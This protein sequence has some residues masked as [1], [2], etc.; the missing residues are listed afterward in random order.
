MATDTKPLRA[1]AVSR[2]LGKAHRRSESYGSM[3]RGIRRHTD[4]FEVFEPTDA[5]VGQ[6]VGV[7]HVNDS[8]RRG[9]E[10]QQ[11]MHSML[12]RYERTLREAGFV[13]ER[14]YINRIRTILRVTR[15]G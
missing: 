12:D 10:A 6:W 14:R 4:G 3:V 7:A 15:E 8:Y 13:V 11:R 2:L 9:E 1:A 5:S